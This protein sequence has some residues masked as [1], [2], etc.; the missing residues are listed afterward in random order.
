MLSITFHVLT[1]LFL[2]EAIESGH[3]P[4]DILD[5]IPVKYVDGALVCEVILVYFL[6][7]LLLKA[8]FKFLSKR[9]SF[10]Q[11]CHTPGA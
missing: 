2:L 11:F 1:F 5:D 8:T 7:A 3:L 4:G 9:L 10:D 6:H